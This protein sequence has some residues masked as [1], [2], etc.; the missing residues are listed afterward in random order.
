[1]FFRLNATFR[2]PLAGQCVNRD[3]KLAGAELK[4][5]S[6]WFDRNQN[7]VSD[8]GEVVPIEQA[9]VASLKVTPNTEDH[10]ATLPATMHTTG[11]RMLDGRELPTWDWV[12]PLAE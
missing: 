9:S 2:K 8:R 10:T 11:L 12:A 6:L 1:M 3:G 7:G 5:L 4:G